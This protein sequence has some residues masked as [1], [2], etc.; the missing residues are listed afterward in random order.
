LRR[1]DRYTVHAAPSDSARDTHHG[2]RSRG[3]DVLRLFVFCLLLSAAGIALAQGPARGQ[4]GK[5]AREQASRPDWTLVRS[6]LLAEALRF[7]LPQEFVPV[8]QG[9]KDKAVTR[10]FVP[11]G[12][13]ADTF[14]RMISVI[15]YQNLSL[16]PLASPSQFAE[17]IANLFRRNCPDSY[18]GASLGARKYQEHDAYAAVLS[19]GLVKPEDP[20]SEATL[21]V[22]IRGEKD[23]FTLQWT[24]RGKPSKVPVRFDPAA[25][26]GRLDSLAPIRMCSAKPGDFPLY[27]GCFKPE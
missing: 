21:L 17:G 8:F 16:S 3:T 9:E 6:P 23:F 15:A 10:E 25:W 4:G 14:T 19:C 18:S 22:V 27:A 26:R 7:N 24:E 12:E 2:P 13:S 1:N 20:Y 5:P 11:K